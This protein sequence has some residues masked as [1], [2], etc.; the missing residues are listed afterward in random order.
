MRVQNFC[1]HYVSVGKLSFMNTKPESRILKF[2]HFSTRN[3]FTT[4]YMEMSN[5]VF[6]KNVCDQ[7]RSFTEAGSIMER[8]FSSLARQKR[9]ENHLSHLRIES[10]TT[11]DTSITHALEKRQADIYK[12]APQ[13]PFHSQTEA[14]RIKYLRKDVIVNSWASHPI[15]QLDLDHLSFQEFFTHLDG[16][17]QREKEEAV[18]KK[19]SVRN[20]E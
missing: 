4:Y 17:I 14:N 3:F 11:P 10:Y 12:L 13:G 1:V 5:D 15:M 2:Q 6:S 20:C 18:A 16:S 19:S 9:T 7:A 8:H